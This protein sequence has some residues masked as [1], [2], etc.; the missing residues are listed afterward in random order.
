MLAGTDNYLAVMTYISTGVGPATIT[1][2]DLAILGAVSGSADAIPA[3]Y[4]G[5][6]STPN[7]NDN[8]STRTFDIH[9]STTG[10]LWV[11]GAT[12]LPAML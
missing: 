8:G 10:T 7:L 4:A 9:H 12:K 2:T 11:I 6:S 1:I 3:F 5:E